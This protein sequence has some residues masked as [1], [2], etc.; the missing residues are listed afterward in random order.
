[1]LNGKNFLLL[2]I[3]VVASLMGH[4]VQYALPMTDPSAAGLVTL[5]FT[6][7]LAC[8]CVFGFDVMTKGVQ[9]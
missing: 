1:M 3:M 6:I 9:L 8:L 2:A 5:F 7:E 4:F